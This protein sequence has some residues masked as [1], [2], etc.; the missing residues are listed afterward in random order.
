LDQSE[1]RSST[2]AYVNLSPGSP[3]LYRMAEMREGDGGNV[4][5]APEMV[6]VL[7]ELGEQGWELIGALGGDN[8]LIFKRRK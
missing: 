1:Y 6:I 5:S 3:H 2:C 4:Y 7:R 8:V